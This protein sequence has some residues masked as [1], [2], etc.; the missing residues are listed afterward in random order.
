MKNIVLTGFMGSGKTA[1]GREL[2]NRLGMKLVELDEEIE[3]AEGLTINEIFSRFGE[4]Y[5]RDRETEIVRKFAG[6]DNVVISTGGGVVLRE[7]NMKALREKGVIVCL[8]ATPETILK[9]TSTSGERPLL[10][11]DDPLKKI[12]DLLDYREPFY[13]KADILI[14]TD[15]LSTA[16]IA[17]EIIRRVK[18]LSE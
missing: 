5:F 14:E 6:Q 16:E 4:R 2:A 10:N 11:V 3:K 13:E 1:V 18:E 15:S 12:R 9:R 17:D 8:K 7:E